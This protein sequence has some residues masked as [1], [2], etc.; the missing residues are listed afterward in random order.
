MNIRL[1]VMLACEGRLASEQAQD[2]LR[3]TTFC[4]SERRL[5]LQ[6]SAKGDAGFSNQG[7]AFHFGSSM[8]VKPRETA[9]YLSASKRKVHSDR[10]S[11][12]VRDQFTTPLAVLEG[13]RA[14]VVE[15]RVATLNAAVAQNNYASG[16]ASF[17]VSHFNAYG[18]Q[19]VLYFHNLGARSG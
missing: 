1:R 12:L 10:L 15:I 3:Q 8:R 5:Q 16:M 2:A 18:I 9:G 19:P 7:G 14:R 13:V 17:S 6:N 4:S 11:M